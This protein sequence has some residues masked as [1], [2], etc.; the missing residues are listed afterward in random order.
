MSILFS[1]LTVGP[2]TL[3][4]R[5][6]VSP[7]C[8]Y[9]A[10]DGC[11][12][13]WH[14]QHLMTLAMS[15]A[16]LVTLE[17][18]A[19]TRDGRIS[20]GD[21]GLY[22][23]DCEAALGRVM[24]AARRVAPQGTLFALQL[25]HAGRKASAHAPWT[26]GG[27]LGAAEDPWP[28]VAPSGLPFGE[29]WPTPAQLDEDGLARLRDAF[30]AAT[31]R[32]VRLGFEVIDLH[33]A[34]GYLLHQFC[35]PLTNRRDDAWGG[36]AARRMAYPLSVVR[37]IRAAMPPDRL[38]TARITGS[39][40]MDGGLGPDDAVAL[41]RALQAEGVGMVCVTTG[42]VVGTARIPV[43]PGYQ[44]PHA[45]AVRQ[46]TGLPTQAVGLI[47]TAEEA[48]AILAAGQADAVALAR[49]FLDDPRWPWQA[50]RAL[51]ATVAVPPQ[52][53]RGA[54]PNWKGR[55]A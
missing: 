53:A 30:V 20:H 28:T 31:V 18:T 39:D 8:Q 40:W 5:I 26:G 9:S 49:A 46:A 7:M 42:G 52:Y 21:L 55:G 13:D 35:S 44:L 23:D 34:H 17:A 45:A 47:R 32:A 41:T 27:P 51:G 48:E 16:G 25:G 43:A 29:A 12:S 2:V 22:S 38:L 54:A 4:N 11:A 1:P 36:D 37:A 6:V 14:M 15:G 50:A 3:P 33:L 19:V 24:A 10:Q